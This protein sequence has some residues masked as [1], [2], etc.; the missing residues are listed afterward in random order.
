MQYMVQLEPNPFILEID[1]NIKEFE[2]IQRIG[3]HDFIPTLKDYE[4]Y[5]I[6][7]GKSEFYTTKYAEYD[8]AI[9]L[10]NSNGIFIELGVF[11]GRS[12]K[13]L[14]GMDLNRVWWDLT[15]L[16]VLMRY[17]KWGVKVLI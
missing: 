6:P 17:G 15:H 7:Q 1:M 4:T 9:P 16:K 10:S 11:K 8:Y 13:Y 12:M 2:N 3:P 5:D 14:S